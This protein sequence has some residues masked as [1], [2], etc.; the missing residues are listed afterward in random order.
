MK[1]GVV[2]RG[3]SPTGGAERYLQRFSAAAA[4]AGH[5]CVLFTGPEWPTG[6]WQGEIARV[7]GSLPSAFAAGLIKAA[8]QK[9]CDTLFSLERVWRCDVYRAGDGVHADW[10]ERRAAYEPRW[11]TMLR[12]LRSKHRQLLALERALFAGNGARAIIANSRM[13]G[14]EIMARFRRPAADIRIIYNG[15]PTFVPNPGARLR[16]RESLGISP[17]AY[18]LLFV[19]SGWER[20]GLRFALEALRRVRAPD[21][22]FLVAGTDRR[23]PGDVP[24]QVKFLGAS[25]KTSE[26][27][28]ASDV[29]VLPTIYD[30]FSNACL[31][32]MAAGLPVITTRSNGFSEIL[33]AGTDGDILEDPDDTT[34]LARCIDNWHS[35]ARRDTVCANLRAKAARFSVEENT[36]RTLEVISSASMPR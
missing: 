20:K 30:P 35:A 9:K 24:A 33:D 28:E 27:L 22:F 17:S 29:F 13:V 34:T 11:R 26:L 3:Y 16:I 12:R 32:A 31:E 18:V 4:E 23:A 14:D 10:L 36:R 7:Q 5:E 1:I 8:A 21:C 19:G 25:E 2:R 6:Q 15:V